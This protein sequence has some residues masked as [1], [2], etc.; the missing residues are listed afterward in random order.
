M[1]QVVVEWWNT[2]SSVVLTLIGVAGL[3]G[4]IRYRHPAQFKVL[5]FLLICIGLGSV[6]FHATMSFAGQM[7]DEI[8]M[9]LFILALVYALVEV[10]LK[11]CAR[12]PALWALPYILT[13]YGTATVAFM[14]FV[15]KEALF[16][17]LCFGVMAFVVVWQVRMPHFVCR[18]HVARASPCALGRS[19]A[20]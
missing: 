19:T 5:H 13:A 18:L 16:F 12:I 14:L 6:W 9:M 20:C 4:A 8:P 11:L 10:D 3:F 1:S 2:V 7:F 17:R 15:S